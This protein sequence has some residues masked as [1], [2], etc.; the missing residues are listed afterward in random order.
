MYIQNISMRIISRIQAASASK[1]LIV[2]LIDLYFTVPF[3]IV[4]STIYGFRFFIW[5]PFLMGV[6]NDHAQLDLRRKI[7]L[8]IP[9]DLIR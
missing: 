1:L 9:S 3:F 8:A 7:F 2:G 5:F 6:A 4:P